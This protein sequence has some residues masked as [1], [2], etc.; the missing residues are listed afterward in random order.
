MSKNVNVDL[1]TYETSADIIRTLF[2]PLHLRI[3]CFCS[4]HKKGH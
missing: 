4:P 2:K 3:G 1:S